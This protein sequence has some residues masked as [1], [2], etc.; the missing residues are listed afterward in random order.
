MVL[1]RI[2]TVICLACLLL[3]SIVLAYRRQRAGQSDASCELIAT[4]SSSNRIVVATSPARAA[5][6]R[7]GIVEAAQSASVG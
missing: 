6:Q 3:S 4:P 1:H 2:W 7:C 5:A